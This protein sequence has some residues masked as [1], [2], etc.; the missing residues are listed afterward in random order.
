MLE[1]TVWGME[2]EDEEKMEERA[3][4]FSRFDL[5]HIYVLTNERASARVRAAKT[6]EV[7]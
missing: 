7:M 1:W 4:G 3:D 5:S 6:P 2:I